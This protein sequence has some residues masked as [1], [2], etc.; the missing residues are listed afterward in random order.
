MYDGK[1]EHQWFE[2]DSTTSSLFKEICTFNKGTGNRKDR[3]QFKSVVRLSKDI[4]C[5]LKE[6]NVDTVR[7]I[8]FKASPNDPNNNDYVFY[9]Y[10]R[11]PC[12]EF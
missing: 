8:K 9:E 7:V 10:E 12:V 1:T 4:E 11:Q 3:C 5:D 6:C 2:P